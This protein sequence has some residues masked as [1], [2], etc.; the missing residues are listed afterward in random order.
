MRAHFRFIFFHRFV[1]A[2][3]DAMLQRNIKFKYMCIICYFFLSSS[4]QSKSTDGRPATATAF[5]CDGYGPAM[6]TG[7]SQRRPLSAPKRWKII[8]LPNVVDRFV[9][10]RHMFSSQKTL[11]HVPLCIFVRG[12][13]TTRRVLSLCQCVAVCFSLQKYVRACE[14]VCASVYAQFVCLQTILHSNFE[15]DP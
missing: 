12:R 4:V 8:I 11:D 7:D 13:K 14:C 15:W 6:A 1:K 3:M 9:Q 10:L 5:S 2:G